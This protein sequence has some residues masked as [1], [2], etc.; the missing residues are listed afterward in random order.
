MPSLDEL[1]AKLRAALD[2]K[3][4]LREEALALSREIIRTSANTIRAGHRGE[5][6]RAQEMLAGAAAA[7]ARLQDRLAESAAGADL[8]G[9]GYVHDCQKEFAEAAVFLAFLAGAEAPDPD[10]LL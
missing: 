4:L 10:D 9:A 7:V 1:G 2:E 3:N 6:A 5:L 8:H